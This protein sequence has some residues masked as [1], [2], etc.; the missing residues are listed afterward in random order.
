MF[1]STAVQKNHFIFG[2]TSTNIRKK[3]KI[4][5]SFI[6]KYF[7]IHF[8]FGFLFITGIQFIPFRF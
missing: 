3:I 4:N 5:L 7:G 2:T 1:F 6:K 8:R